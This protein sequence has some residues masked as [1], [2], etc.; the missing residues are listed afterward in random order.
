MVEKKM[1]KTANE[2]SIN[3]WGNNAYRPVYRR[4]GRHG[5]GP[6]CSLPP[7][8]WRWGPVAMTTG[9]PQSQTRRERGNV[10]QR[11][12]RGH[13]LSQEEKE[14]NLF[15]GPSSSPFRFPFLF[16]IIPS[17]AVLLFSLFIFYLFIW[18]CCWLRRQFT[19]TWLTTGSNPTAPALTELFT[20]SIFIE[21][22]RPIFELS[23]IGVRVSA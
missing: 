15:F 22:G 13:D 16:I 18:P 7:F 8:P 2:S 14:K 12:T 19:G 9:Q 11:S 17:W 21:R 3:L 1:K 6:F 10:P 4:L 20:E 5:N 23:L